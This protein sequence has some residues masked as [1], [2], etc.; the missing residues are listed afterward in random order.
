VVTGVDIAHPGSVVAAPASA[1][2]RH[3]PG[4][5]PRSAVITT[6]MRLVA[7]IP[8]QSA[9]SAQLRF[10]L[11]ILSR[12]ARAGEYDAA[13]NRHLGGRLRDLRENDGMDGARLAA[14]LQ[15]TTE[16]ISGYEQGSIQI[17]SDTLLR[18]CRVFNVDPS[19]FFNEFDVDE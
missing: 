5:A 19:Y 7:I 10:P 3:N 8:H 15:A 14:K 2:C 11:T 12:S 1:W 6:Q 17:S 16:E 18:L 13:I 9:F 4:I